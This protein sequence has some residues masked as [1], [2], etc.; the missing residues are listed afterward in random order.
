MNSKIKN[1]LFGNGPQFDRKIEA[2][3]EDVASGI[4][5]AFLCGGLLGLLVFFLIIKK[6]LKIISYTFYNKKKNKN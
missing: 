4:L 3:G 5:Y 1:I 2:R 6:I